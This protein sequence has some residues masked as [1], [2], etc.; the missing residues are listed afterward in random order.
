MNSGRR[1]STAE[2]PGARTRAGSL[3]GPAIG[4][5]VEVQGG[6]GIVRFSGTTDF[7]TGK[8]IGIELDSPQGKNDGSVQGKRYFECAMGHGIF[9]R[10]SQVK[11]VISSSAPASDQEPRAR[12][13]PSTPAPET[14]RVARRATIAP[15]RVSSAIASP[16]PSRLGGS[17]ISSPALGTRSGLTGRRVSDA[18]QALGPRRMTLSSAGMRSSSRQTAVSDN[19]GSAAISRPGS[20]QTSEEQVAATVA[21]T[22]AALSTRPAESASIR[23]ATPEEDSDAMQVDEPA[24]TTYRP[25]LSMDESSTFASSSAPAPTLSEQSVPM[26]QYEEL[27]LKY[28]FLE[29]KRS[30][31]RQRIQEADKIRA[32]AEQ[33]LRVRDKLVAKVSAQQEEVRALKLR[34]KQ[35]SEEHDELE[36]RVADLTDA[37]E[38]QTVD[39]E[40]AEERAEALAAELGAM[41][42][43]LEETTTSLDV[44]RQ[45]GG[46]GGG[47]VATDIEAQRQIERL[48][49]ALVRL[50]D[51]SAAKEA[52]LS[53]RQRD[54]ER[55]KSSAASLS[56]ECERLR[57][58]V[59]ASESQVED[60]R[61]RLDEALSSEEMIEELAARNL[62]LGQR[63]E[64]LQGVVES[65]EALCEVNNEMEET[66]AEEEQGLRAEISRLQAT[67]N[68]R[69]RRCEKLEEAMAETQFTV[70]Q[71]RELV[72]T[73]QGDLQRMQ[74]VAQTQA[75]ETAHMTSQTQEMLSLQMK[76][77][78]TAMRSRAAAVDLELRRL[79]AEQAAEELRMTAPFVPDAFFASEADALRAL[80][81]FRRVAAKADIL[82]RQLEAPESEGTVSDDFVAVADVRAQL[83][84]LAGAAMLVAGGMTCA[85]EADFARGA[86]L[87][88]DASVSERR[89][90]GLLSLLRQE[91][92]RAADALPEV[93]RLASQAEALASSNVPADAAIAVRVEAQ[94]AAVAYGAEVQLANFVYTEQ[95]LAPADGSLGTVAASVVANVKSTKATAL[96]L[97]RRA[98][99]LRSASLVVDASAVEH[100]ARITRASA[101]LSEYAARLRSAVQDTVA[102]NASQL[103][104]A[105]ASVAQDV[106]GT[107]GDVGLSPAMTAVQKLAQSL[108]AV[109]PLLE[110]AAPDTSATAEA[111]WMRRAAAF[112]T[113]LVQNADVERR[114]SAL[115][116][117]I[118]SLARELKLRDQALQESGVRVEMLEKRTETMRRQADQDRSLQSA[119]DRAKA[120]EQTYEE[121]IESLQVEMDNL[122]TECRKLRQEAATAAANSRASQPAQDTM[123][124]D[125]LGLR[126]KVTALLESVAFLQRENAHL[127]A[128]QLF[129]AQSTW[130]APLRTEYVARKKTSS[131]MDDAVREA[132]LVVR[133]AC[134][135]AAMPRLVRLAPPE[136]SS[137]D[138][139][140][141]ED[142]VPTT[143][144]AS[145]V[146]TWKPLS[147]R[148]QFDL[149]R[150]QTLAQTLKQRAESVQD[151][152]RSLSITRLPSIATPVL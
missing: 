50:R 37:V 89:L 86:V 69:T 73:L 43:Q 66:R 82:C 126:A 45:T 85:S 56:E 9:V 13:L 8:W 114:T 146:A 19:S 130:S 128:K 51:H 97:L 17:Q 103:P 33:A 96:R 141:E 22:V 144:P 44:Y 121:A 49:E 124:S 149:Y 46:A 25:A 120:K 38:M 36:A 102:H 137:A 18:Q 104:Q 41:R 65:L 79:D 107:Q 21:A 71:Y 27:R 53:Q 148:P 81:A 133:E 16:G 10:S 108:S 87:L 68:D 24:R 147:A 61:E 135:L 1:L 151:R 35:A 39:K 143:K 145:A 123:P 7:G 23:P 11:V 84:Q 32:E 118:V 140:M 20:Q 6:R 139:Q 63:V 29:Q 30:E 105:L 91:E 98:K 70:K 40:M 3:A 4:Q 92:F 93:R 111:P 57:T 116:E 95:L 109:L 2:S 12:A 119:L 80:L 112:K 90:D 127:R 67:I 15:G 99:E 152:L 129:A 78:T 54:L 47:G 117:E 83:A 74:A 106:F 101:E 125:L 88:H 131:D 42:E 132:R 59:A 31:D 5:A 55:E 58:R 72:S 115:R 75:T 150:Q 48:K 110:N 34:V 113:S 136:S 26:K 134:R 142:G 122:E 100:I 94:A 62:D 138:V 60:L 28:K 76:L 77:R 52:E 14:T 64:E